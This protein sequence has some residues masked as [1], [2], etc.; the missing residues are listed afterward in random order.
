ML[1]FTLDHFIVP[2]RARLRPISTGIL[3]KI[4]NSSNPLLQSSAS[5]GLRYRTGAGGRH[6]FRLVVGLLRL[7]TSPFLIGW[8]PMA[9]TMGIVALL[10]G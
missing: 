1:D 7:V 5:F 8:P 4:L 2:G 6:R 3:T 9:K 10:S